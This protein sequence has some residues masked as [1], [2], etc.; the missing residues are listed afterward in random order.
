M[1]AT[2]KADSNQQKTGT[3]TP[4]SESTTGSLGAIEKAVKAQLGENGGK[5]I[6]K[7]YL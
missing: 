3:D 4:D 7:K 6:G 2:L 1:I 5:D